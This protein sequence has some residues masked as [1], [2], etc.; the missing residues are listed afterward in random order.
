MYLFHQKITKEL[1]D[2]IGLETTIEEID[3][4]LLKSKIRSRKHDVGEGAIIVASE[5]IFYFLFLQKLKEYW[6]TARNSKTLLTKEIKKY[7]H[8]LKGEDLCLS[9]KDID[10]ILSILEVKLEQIKVVETFIKNLE[11]STKF[12]CYKNN[13]KLALHYSKLFKSYFG[14]SVVLEDYFLAHAYH[15][16]LSHSSSQQD[17]IRREMIKAVIKL[18]GKPP[19]IEK[20]ITRGNREIK[21]ISKLS[22]GKIP[23]ITSW[24]Y[25]GKRFAHRKQT[26]SNRTYKKRG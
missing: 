2:I 12:R 15:N 16:L 19:F 4:V 10:L 24:D 20:L 17:I 9:S 23:D 22:N 26:K 1:L 21:A 25:S 11:A 7:K 5:N 8:S 6:R 13:R 3:N 14:R 18:N